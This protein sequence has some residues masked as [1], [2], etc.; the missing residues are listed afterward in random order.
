M[1]LRN[2]IN[3]YTAFLFALLLVILNITVYFTFNTLLVN[4]ELTTAHKEMEKITENFGESLGQIPDDTLLRSYLPVNGMIQIVTENSMN[5]PLITSADEQNLSKRKPE[6]YRNEVSKK[7]V[8]EKRQYSFES[9]PIIM[10]DGSVANLQITKSMETSNKIL[11]ILRLVLILV[12][13]LALIPVLISS[14]LLSNF[15]TKPVTSMIKTMTEIQKSGTFKTIKL[16]GQSKDELFQMGQTFNHMIELLETNFEKQ[17]QFV[18]NASHELKT[19]LTIIESYASLLKRRGLTEPKLFMESIEA[20][21]SEALRMKEMTE[22]LLVLARHHEQWNIEVNKVNLNQLLD[23]TV[24]AFKNAYKREIELKA[25]TESPLFFESDEKKLKQLLYIFLDN[26]RKYS[27]DLISVILGKKDDEI[28][29]KIIDR[30]IGIQNS[31]LPKVFDRFYRVDKARSRKQGGS[32]L[33]LSIAKE[34]ADAVGIAVQL[35]SEPGIGTTATLL[36]KKVEK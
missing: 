16:E 18:S 17:E 32:G 33:G 26:A 7:I 14:R 12:T 31:E 30:G 36:I 10:K 2:K 22:Q 11:S 29:I 9:M 24:N 13:L 6:Y 34:I 20:I 8:F 27:D 35:E 25:M 4:S 28:F 3:L 15:I 23:Q 1:K 5:P 21:H 19:P